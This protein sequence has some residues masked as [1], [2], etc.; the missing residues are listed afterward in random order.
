M[1]GEDVLIIYL[2][3]SRM[4]TTILD[5]PSIVEPALPCKMAASVYTN[6]EQVAIATVLPS[7]T[8]EA[9]IADLQSKRPPQT[10]EDIPYKR[11]QSSAAPPIEEPKPR[12]S[13]TRYVE[14]WTSGVNQCEQERKE[15][16]DEGGYGDEDEEEDE[17]SPITKPRKIS[18]QK[19]RQNYIA[20]SYIQTALE[21]SLQKVLGVKPEEEAQQS[22]RWLINQSESHQIISTPRAYQTELFEKAKEKNIIAVL[23]TG[24]HVLDIDAPKL[25]LQ[26]LEKH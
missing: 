20:D 8:T 6:P 25:I 23:D 22:A 4:S 15:Q 24:K 7:R 21:K 1:E 5:Y 3:I 19:R 17:I 10:F 13:K 26:A 12:L 2:V 18:E 9:V 14:E 16:E 11:L